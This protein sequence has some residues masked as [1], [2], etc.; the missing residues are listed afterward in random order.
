MIKIRKVRKALVL[1]S[2]ILAMTSA[3]KLGQGV[4]S[5]YAL[6]GAD[7]NYD[8]S[9][10]CEQSITEVTKKLQERSLFLDEI[11]AR[12][13]ER[14]AALL[15]G[16]KALQERIH[17]LTMAEEKL[18]STLS[19]ADGAAEKDIRTLGEIY[20]AMK[21]EDAAKIFDIMTPEYSAGLLLALSPESSAA[22]LSN[23]KPEHVYKI[24]TIIAGRNTGTPRE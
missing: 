15:L 12:S 5:V 23:M 13:N 3:I 1:S 8:T 11:E 20:E 19:I 21:S 14:N 10:E 7:I 18:K 9:R 22:I 2:L 6:Q 17:E 4:G 24:S 16:E